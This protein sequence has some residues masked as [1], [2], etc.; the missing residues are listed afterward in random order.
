MFRDSLNYAKEHWVKE[1]ENPPVGLILCS[2]KDEAL[3]RYALQ[4]LPNTVMALEY[5]ITLP[6]EDLLAAEL[7]RTRQEIELRASLSFP[8]LTAS[9]T[10]SVRGPEERRE[11]AQGEE[12][13]DSVGSTLVPTVPTENALP[14]G[15]VDMVWDRR[16]GFQCEG[17]GRE[18][19][20]GGRLESL[21]C[22]NPACIYD[23]APYNQNAIL[24][25]MLD[26]ASLSPYHQEIR[27]TLNERQAPRP[28]RPYLFRLV[29]QQ[30]EE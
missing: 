16:Y 8:P 9:A 6:G 28:M 5:R 1:G 13:T 22:R 4:G 3:A 24:H 17:C 26:A 30:S 19:T 29:D 23:D 12:V 7:E 25:V 21:V 27:R 2:E 18:A 20:L 11:T 14:T 15:G 10:L